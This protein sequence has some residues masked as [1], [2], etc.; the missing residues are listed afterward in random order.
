MLLLLKKL[1]TQNRNII[2]NLA[3]FNAVNRTSMNSEV[4]LMGRSLFYQSSNRM[5]KESVIC[6]SFLNNKAG[7]P[8]E[9][10]QLS[11]LIDLQNI[12]LSPCCNQTKHIGVF[13]LFRDH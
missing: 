2:T 13:M 12:F 1:T 5:P 9:K 7:E 3:M 6:A 8:L 11:A 4:S 10:G